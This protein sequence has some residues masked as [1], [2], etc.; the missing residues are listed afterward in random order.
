[1]SHSPNIETIRRI[2]YLFGVEESGLLIYEGE[3]LLTANIDINDKPNFHKS[4]REWTGEDYTIIDPLQ[5]RYPKSLVASKNYRP[6][7]PVKNDQGIND[8]NQRLEKL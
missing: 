1:M 4:L 2:C 7:M 5:E 8:I 3:Y 6:I